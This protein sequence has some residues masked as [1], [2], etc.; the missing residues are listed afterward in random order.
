MSNETGELLSAKEPVQRFGYGVQELLRRGLVEPVLVCTDG[1]PEPSDLHYVLKPAQEEQAMESISNEET[2]I[3]SNAILNNLISFM[4]QLAASGMEHKDI[5]PRGY[6]FALAK[7]RS[8]ADME[9]SQGREISATMLAQIMDHAADLLK[10]A[11]GRGIE[12]DHTNSA[13]TMQSGDTHITV[14]L[15]GKVLAKAVNAE[16]ARGLR[17]YGGVRAK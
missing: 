14:T 2:G 11:V 16:Q 10:A 15:D 3:T 12:Q 17:R 13:P 7:L 8:K 5:V 9:L 4:E 6:D 1:K